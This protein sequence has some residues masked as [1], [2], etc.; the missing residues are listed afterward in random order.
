M[1]SRLCRREFQI[2]SN[3]NSASLRPVIAGSGRASAMASATPISLAEGQPSSAG[4]NVSQMASSERCCAAVNFM[5]CFP[6]LPE[7]E[8]MRHFSLAK[9]RC[10]VR[11]GHIQRAEK[12]KGEAGQVFPR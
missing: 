12:K 8:E 1:V 11:G 2:S 4:A 7:L 9:R 3:C 10:E 5:G 6:V